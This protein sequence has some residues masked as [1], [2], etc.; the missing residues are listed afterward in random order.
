MLKIDNSF[1]APLSRSYKEIG[2]ILMNAI[3]VCGVKE[4]KEVLNEAILE[5]EK[6]QKQ[7]IRLKEILESE[8]A[9]CI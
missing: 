9:K 4:L 5:S 3:K 8:G 7:A 1:V 2:E 6:A